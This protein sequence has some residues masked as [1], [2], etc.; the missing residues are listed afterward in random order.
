MRVDDDG[1]VVS[2]LAAADVD[3]VVVTPAHQYPTGVVMS[4]ERRSALISWARDRRA[5]IV[6]DDYDAEYRY[7][8]D[9]V[10]S[11][12][13]LAPDH[14]AFV[15]TTSKTLAPALRLG[16]IV[17]PASL[18]DDVENQFLATGVTPPTLDQVAMASF[19]ADAGLDRH[20]RAMRRHYRAK[21]DTLIQA[22]M[23]HLPDVRVG[24]AAAGLHLVAWLPEAATNMAQPSGPAVPGS[25]FT[26]CTRI[27]R[28]GHRG[29]QHCC[30]ATPYP[31][32]PRS[33]QEHGCLPK[34][35]AQS[36]WPHLKRADWTLPA[37]QS[38]LRM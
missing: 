1:L 9:P 38:S 15:G 22:L 3:A 2:E 11:L 17:P 26:S 7:D 18:L 5:L 25:G 10:A 31:P 36:N 29:R 27:A 21:R 14:V 35:W 34:L 13:G 37:G 16:W 12:Q 20:L 8:R 33:G 4:P 23:R 19:I 24:G 30:W 28:R 6:E 32:R